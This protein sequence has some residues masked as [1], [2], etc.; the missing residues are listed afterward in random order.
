M[1]YKYSFHLKP[2]KKTEKSSRQAAVL[3]KPCNVFEYIIRCSAI[4][5]SD[6]ESG[7]GL[8]KVN[9]PPCI[10]RNG[11]SPFAFRRLIGPATDVAPASVARYRQVAP[12]V[13]P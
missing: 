10:R 6:G 13:A 2:I 12:R 11:P 5:Q 7:C 8:R 1:N 3:V 4:F 9:K